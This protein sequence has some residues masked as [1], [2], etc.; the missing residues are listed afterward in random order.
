M[1][2][3]A[4]KVARMFGKTAYKDFRDGFGTLNCLDADSDSS[5]KG[6]LGI[7]QKNCGAIAVMALE[8]HYAATLAYERELRRA[9]DVH[10]G[11]AKDPNSYPVRRL[12]V[13]IAIRQHAHVPMSQREIVEWAWVLRTRRETVE[14]A[15]RDAMIWLEDLTSRAAS[16]FIAA[17]R[18]KDNEAA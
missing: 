14:D 18:D 3:T 7:A 11:I 17:M 1:S 10:C 9:W 2:A 16:A 6:S 8:T 12:G 5:I 13:S 4:E 15:I